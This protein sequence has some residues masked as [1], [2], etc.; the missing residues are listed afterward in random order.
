MTFNRIGFR[1][2]SLLPIIYLVFQ[3]MATKNY[4]IKLQEDASNLRMVI[5][6]DNTIIE[7]F[8]ATR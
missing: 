4:L 6:I 7:P 3:D 2:K 5:S 8:L 1:R